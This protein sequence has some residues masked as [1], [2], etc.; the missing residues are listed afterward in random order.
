MTKEQMNKLNGFVELTE[1]ELM[2]VSGGKD[3]RIS[4]SRYF[5]VE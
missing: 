4:F 3:E 2:E 1:A 5:I